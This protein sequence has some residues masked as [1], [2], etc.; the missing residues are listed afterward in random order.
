MMKVTNMTSNNGNDVPNQ[1][2]ISDAVITYKS[3]T[4]ETITPPR[5][6][7]FQSYNSNIAFIGGDGSTFLDERY[8]DYSKTTGTY[9]N[10][11]LGEGIADTRKKIKSGEYRLVDLN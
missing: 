6:E 9:R 8:W 3:R 7:M 10:Q 2:L 5:G 1:F 11:F 4:G